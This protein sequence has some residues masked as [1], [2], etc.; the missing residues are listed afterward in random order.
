MFGAERLAGEL[1]DLGYE[2]KIVK[3]SDDQDYVVIDEYEIQA[4]LFGGRIIE[5][6]LFAMQEYPRNV[7]SAIHIKAEPQL[8]ETQNVPNVRNITA[9]NL[10]PEWRYWSHNF[11]WTEERNARRLM[12]QINTIFENA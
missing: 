4:G 2:A 1:R 9:S 8:Y 10:G 12:S 6:G 11:N 5:L 3:G 7:G